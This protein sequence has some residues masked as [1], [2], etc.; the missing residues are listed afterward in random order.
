MP[1][2]RIDSGRRRTRLLS[3]D[4]AGIAEA[5][6]ILRAGGF[7]SHLIDLANGSS[8]DMIANA[9]KVL[10]HAV[11]LVDLEALTGVPMIDNV[12]QSKFITFHDYAAGAALSFSLMA[13]VLVLI[14]LY[15]RVLGTEE[16]STV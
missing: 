1:V 4:A 8:H 5:A 14:V 15:A 3:A 16:V 10:G 9:Q 7:P 13:I 2:M 6:A 12:I 11:V